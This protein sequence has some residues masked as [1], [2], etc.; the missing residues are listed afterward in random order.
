MSIHMSSAADT[1]HSDYG[2]LSE[3]AA[4]APV[5]SPQ[6]TSASNDELPT[7]RPSRTRG[8]RAASPAGQPDNRYAVPSGYANLN[9]LAASSP[10][11]N[12][13]E[14]QQY[15]AEYLEDTRSHE[16]EYEHDVEREQSRQQ[17][18]GDNNRGAEQVGGEE[19]SSSNT[20][21]S[22]PRRRERASRLVTALYTLS[23]LVL[24]SI[25]GTLARLGIEGL[26]TYPGYPVTTSVLWANFSGSLIMG[27]LSE[28]RKLFKHHEVSRNS[29]TQ[30]EEQRAQRATKEDVDIEADREAAKKSHMAIK[31]TIPL[32][33]GLTTGFC[34]SFTSFSSFIR[35][36]FLAL[37]NAAPTNSGSGTTHSA[38]SRNG[39]DDF[40]ALVAIVILTV[41][42]CLSA[43]QLG[44]HVAIALERFT[45]ALPIFLTHKILDHCIAVLAWGIWLGAV[46]MAIWPPDRPSGSSAG[47]RTTWAQE[48]WR[49][50][51]IF[52]LVFAPLG[53]LAR[54]YASIYL[55]GIFVSFPLG[56]FTVNVFGTAILGMA[57][58]L[59]HASLGSAIHSVGGG[60]V[61]CQVL[62]GVQDGFCG[63]LTTVSTWVLE[64]KSL[65][66]KHAYFY[67][68]VSIC[69]ALAFLVAIMGSLQWT[70][71][72]SEPACST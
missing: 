72:F 19:S 21:D 41:C 65:R 68:M 58:D 53:T 64:L 69:I 7:S 37:S 39:G 51:V 54:F 44:A 52:A 35:D 20:K 36:V 49:G 34:G 59:Q 47:G 62:Q 12:P 16:Q 30:G 29:S 43:L 15:G 5:N 1:T 23:Y 14:Q 26:T 17:S 61:G 38:L 9:E 33:I 70:Q 56:T 8:Q 55:N 13:D 28:D 40:M 46:I 4:A 32:Y 71:G 31:K 18:H 60:R 67:G 11:E 6:E 10:V 63:C 66:R 45:P 48:T 2:D 27:F 24:F 50:E 3:V 25:L 22:V 42:L 57:W